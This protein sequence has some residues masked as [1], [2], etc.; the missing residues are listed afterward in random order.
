MHITYSL[1]DSPHHDAHIEGTLMLENTGHGLNNSSCRHSSEWAT[2]AQK[3]QYSNHILFTFFNTRYVCQPRVPWFGCVCNA[4]TM[5]FRNTGH[6]LN[7]S[8]NCYAYERARNIV[9]SQ[10]TTTCLYTSLE[11]DVKIPQMMRKLRGV[12]AGGMRHTSMPRIKE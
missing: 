4:D 10:S 1:P 3:I 12:N 2:N 8:L 7:N 6:G 9:K 5:S 11:K